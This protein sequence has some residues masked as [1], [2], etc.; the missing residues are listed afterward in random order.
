MNT[1]FFPFSFEKTVMRNYGAYLLDHPGQALLLANAA[2]AWRQADKNAVI[3]DWVR[4]HAP[5]LTQLNQ[6]NTFSRGLSLGQLGGINANVIDPIA[7][8][9]AKDAQAHANSP[10]DLLWN[11]FAPQS[12]GPQWTK[13]NLDSYLPLKK[14]FEQLWQT[15]TDEAHIGW[16]AA[17]N[18]LDPLTHDQPR[19]IVAPSQQLG[20][21]L[22]AK[23]NM[24]AQAQ[25]TIDY[26]NAQSSDAD[27]VPW[28]YQKGLP[29][30]IQGKPVDKTTIG[31]YIQYLYPGYNPAK[32]ASNAQAKARQAEAFIR[33]VAKTDPQTA[34][35]MTAFNTAATSLLGKINSDTYDHATLAQTQ[36]QFA[37]SAKQMAEHDPRWLTFYNNYWQKVIGPIT[38]WTGKGTQ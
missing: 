3:G 5:A 13:K 26:N 20:I 29:A 6:L 1:V 32:A 12:W 11:L 4:A 14:E 25:A 35:D 15:T 36:E 21:A 28:P 33:N 8:T 17:A 22:Q 10:S 27:K 34:A 30:D 23:A 24:V 19:S 16:N 38:D 7:S 31:L 18:A 37:E 9:V 2:E